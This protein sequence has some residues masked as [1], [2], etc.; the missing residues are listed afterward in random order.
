MLH[1]KDS[2]SFYIFKDLRAQQNGTVPVGNEVL[3]FD[4]LQDA[5]DEFNRLPNEWTTA[6]GVQVD[7]REIDLVQRREGAPILSGDY[8][9]IAFYSGNREVNTVV[10]TLVDKLSIEWQSDYRIFGS[11]PI[12]FP[13]EPNLDYIRDRFLNGKHLYPDD[14]RHLITAIREAYI[15]EK[16]WLPL[17]DV[18]D[19]VQAF[20]Y[21]NPHT[22]KITKLHVRYADENGKVSEGDVSP[23]N[24][25]LLKER[26]LLMGR[27]T[28]ASKALAGALED[29]LARQAW[30]VRFKNIAG[31]VERIQDRDLTALAEPVVSEIERGLSSDFKRSQA[32]EL[33]GRIMNIPENPD[34]KMPLDLR[35]RANR[36]LEVLYRQETPAKTPGQVIAPDLK[37]GR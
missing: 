36:A 10:N 30:S 1:N 15:P 19:A 26:T 14:P 11:K 32:R 8:Q 21:N 33:L 3:R 27:D 29:F 34:K 24:F 6:L 12:M 22:P 37:E 20:G 16:G 18:Y 31:L 17:A 23:Y 28:D 5:I 25:I 7:S 35:M 9:R 4:K 13:I 2:I